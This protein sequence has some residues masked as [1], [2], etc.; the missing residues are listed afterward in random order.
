MKII[1]LSQRKFKE[2]TPLE[3]PKEI[4]NTE[5]KMFN[6]KYKNGYKIFKKLHQQSGQAFA[7]KLYT[8]EMLDVNKDYLPDYFFESD[9]LVSVGGTIEGFTVPY[10]TGITLS[11]LLNDKKSDP[12]ISIFY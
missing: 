12:S 5:A 7:N 4:F 1:S 11:I 10:A 3:L 2:L 8:L 9:Y 6:F